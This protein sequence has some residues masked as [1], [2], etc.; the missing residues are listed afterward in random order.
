MME[1]FK[2]LQDYEAASRAL[3]EYLKT[4]FQF[5]QSCRVQLMH[6]EHPDPTKSIFDPEAR[7]GFKWVPDQELTAAT[8]VCISR[9]LYQPGVVVKTAA[10]R[11][12]LIPPRSIFFEG[13]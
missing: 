6:L 4:Q 3:Q 8:V 9:M 7:S 2:I 11:E 1:E 5:G 12:M 10:G 13:D